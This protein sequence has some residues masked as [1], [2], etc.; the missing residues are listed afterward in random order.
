MLRVE[1]TARFIR[2]ALE[3]G[4]LGPVCV[5]RA[6][7]PARRVVRVAPKPE[8]S[9]PSRLLRAQSAGRLVREARQSGTAPRPVALLG[10]RAPAQLNGSV[11]R[12]PAPE[13]IGAI[14][15]NTVSLQVA[16]QISAPGPVGL[17]GAN[18]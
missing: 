14:R 16:G 6:E 9:R 15:D 8:A 11:Q 7:V 1:G 2:E 3:A 13:P 10:S 4:A 18:G 5:L 12:A 17:L